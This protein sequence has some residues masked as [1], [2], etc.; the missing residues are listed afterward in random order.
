[1]GG[2]I[3]TPCLPVRSGFVVFVRKSPGRSGATKVLIAERRDGRDVVLEHVGT[4]HDEAELAALMA[5]ARKKLY[6]GQGELALEG[7]S[8]P[9]AEG[10]A[11][12]AVITSKSNVV[13]WQ[14]LRA[15]YDRLGFDAID[16][17]AFAQL[18]LARIVEPTTRPIRCACWTT[19]G[20]CTRRCARCSGL[21]AG[22]RTAT[23]GPRS[24]PRASLTQSWPAT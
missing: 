10:R 15:G 17:E 2:L 21:C 6:P 8:G 3:D 20:F 5:L 13:L 4:A 19:W 1:V 9:V 11:G 23:T 18:V 24:R 7:I 16:D 22:P 12:A 14:V